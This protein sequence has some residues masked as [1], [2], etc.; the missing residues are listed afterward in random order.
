MV[1][2]V[3]ISILQTLKTYKVRERPNFIFWCLPSAN[4]ADRSDDSRTDRQ[5]DR[6][7]KEFWVTSGPSVVTGR[8]QSFSIEKE[9]NYDHSWCGVET[10]NIYIDAHPVLSTIFMCVETRNVA[11]NVLIS[12]NFCVNLDC[13]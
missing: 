2:T 9:V 4:P 11:I 12:A 1:V 10:R 3:S 13:V 7:K 8:F 6:H 5:T